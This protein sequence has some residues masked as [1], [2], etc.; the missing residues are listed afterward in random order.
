MTLKS[1][2]FAPATVANLN[3]GFDIL[4]LSLTKIGDTV[5]VVENGTTE[6]RI[7]E[8]KNGDNLP[9]DV[10]KNACSVVINA[11]QKHLGDTVGLD[12]WIEKGFESGSGLGSSSA[13]SAAAA[14]C[15]N[16]Y[17]KNVFTSLELVQF[18]AKGEEIAC[19]SAHLDNVAPAIFGGI[20]L[21]KDEQTILSLPIPDDLFLVLLF[22]KVEIKTS[23]ARRILPKKIDLKTSIKQNAHLASLVAALY[24]KDYQLM[25]NSFVDFMAEPH[26]KVLI[27]NFDELKII[28][29]SHGAI[30][31]GIS[32]SGP[33]V[34]CLT[35]G[36][37][38]AEKIKKNFEKLIKNQHIPFDCFIDT[39]K[40]KNN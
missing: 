9:F 28:A 24:E 35:K 8:I 29:E 21:V 19:G 11:M 14:L 3:A 23:D 32:G 2:A 18:A 37:E 36:L 15:Y 27:P 26:R 7:I 13:S 31:F 33:S 20:T 5:S 17:K 40:P 16:L 39:I 4:G 12:I 22:Q 25:K 38:T 6:N 34:F 30:T 1:T 10:T